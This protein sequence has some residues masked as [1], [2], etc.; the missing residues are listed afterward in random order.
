MHPL[1]K[2]VVLKDYILDQEDFIADI[3]VRLKGLKDGPDDLD[4]ICCECWSY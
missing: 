1:K 3:V 2:F 4:S